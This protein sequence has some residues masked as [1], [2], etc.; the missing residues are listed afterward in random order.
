M[1][2]LTIVHAQ[3]QDSYEVPAGANLRETMLREGHSPY[4]PIARKL[5][6]GG[7][8]LCA[9]CGVE[10]LEGEPVPQHWHDKAAKRFRYPR[11]SCQIALEQDM[12]VR[13]MEEKK[14]WGKRF[15]KASAK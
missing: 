13:V 5:N 4:A 14:I 12:T 2:I 15:P 9:T 1:P 8:G 3:G 11:L 6:C 7:R 10:I